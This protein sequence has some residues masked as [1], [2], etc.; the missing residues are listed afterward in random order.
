MLQTPNQ[1]PAHQEEASNHKGVSIAVFVHH[2]LDFKIL[3]YLSKNNNGIE[4]LLTEISQDH[5]K[6]ILTSVIY[7]SP[8]ENATE[9]I[10]TMNNLLK[11]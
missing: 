2:K 9:F 6:N 7:R 11:N 5:S 10:N 3:K 1:I 4:S 8:T